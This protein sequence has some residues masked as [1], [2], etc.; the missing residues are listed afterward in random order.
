M[1]KKLCSFDL[2][3]TVHAKKKFKCD[4]CEYS[5]ST[6]GLLKRHEELKHTGQDS[7]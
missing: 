6:P 7:V 3:A 1:H 4:Q 2:Q 5:S